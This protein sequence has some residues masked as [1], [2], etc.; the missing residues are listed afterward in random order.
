MLL[1]AFLDFVAVGNLVAAGVASPG[2]RALL[3]ESARFPEPDSYFFT[4]K[5]EEGEKGKEG[6]LNR[7]E[8]REKD[9]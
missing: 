2:S 8:V 9:G 1:Q 6:F 5:R 3:I 7:P 4:R